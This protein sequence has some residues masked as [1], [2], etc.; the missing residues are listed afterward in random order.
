[1]DTP[2]LPRKRKRI[3]QAVGGR[4]RKTDAERQLKGVT[5]R[6]T[7]ERYEELQ[8]YAA[9]GGRSLA[10]VVRALLN[11][12]LPYLTTQ[13]EGLLRNIATMSNNLNQLAKKAHQSCFE[14][15][16]NDVQQ[17]VERLRE[18]LNYFEKSRD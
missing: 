5:V 9:E 16:A 7:T 4:P 15:V 6:L 10:H 14:A 17:E 18:L 8:G 11:G 12:K 2:E 1:M 13:Q 3:G